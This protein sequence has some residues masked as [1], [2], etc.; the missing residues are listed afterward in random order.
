MKQYIA[1]RIER[2]WT[3]QQIIDGLVDEF[4]PEILTTPPK[5]GFDLVAWLVPALLVAA[6]LAA[7]PF[8]VRGWSRRQ[9][10]AGPDP[11]AP[12]AE[13]DRRLDDELR[14]LGD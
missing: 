12:S 10:P 7:I 3:K 6:G 14:R 8:L 9:R 5:S 11:P 1:E 2:D 4:G 13:E